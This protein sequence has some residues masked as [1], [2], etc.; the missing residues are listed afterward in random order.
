MNSISDMS[1]I[2]YEGP[3]VTRAEIQGWYNL[4]G[5]TFKRK[6]EEKGIILPKGRVCPID[7]QW[8]IRNLGKPKNFGIIIKRYDPGK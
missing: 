6:L 3:A 1:F 4:S 2:I 5:K 8:I 7:V